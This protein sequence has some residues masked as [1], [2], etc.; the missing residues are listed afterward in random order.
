MQSYA[1][2]L[3]MIMVDF[4]KLTKKSSVL[5]DVVHRRRR[6]T[7][8]GRRLMSSAVER[9]WLR[10]WDSENQCFFVNYDKNDDENDENILNHR[11]RD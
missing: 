8:V 3:W 2:I 9:R 5:T 6:R 4:S 7:D 10:Q 11:R 1:V